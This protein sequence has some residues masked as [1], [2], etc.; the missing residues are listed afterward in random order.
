MVGMTHVTEEQL[1][2]FVDRYLR[3][4]HEADPAMRQQ[5]VSSLWA[6]DAV[7]FTETNEHRR[8]Y[9]QA[10]SSRS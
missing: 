4:W 5:L 10:R 8:Q 2:G 7:E 9:G 3:V 1:G 6:A